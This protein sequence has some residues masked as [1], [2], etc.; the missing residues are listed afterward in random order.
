MA[1]RTSHGWWAYLG[2]YAFFLVMV[3]IS[4]RAPHAWA[5][6]LFVA[7]VLGTGGWL[8]WFVRAGALPE[9]R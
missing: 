4:G 1:A 5:P 2:P 3:E 7:R 9:L 6:W 8:L